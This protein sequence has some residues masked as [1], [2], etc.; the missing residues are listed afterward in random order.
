[1]KTDKFEKTIRQKLEGI[2]PDFQEDNWVQMQN[3]MQAHTP[4]TIWQQYSSWVGYAAAA[5]VT[6]VIAF[7]Y[8]N[9][10]TQ[11][12]DLVADVAKLK[13]QIEHINNTSKAL[14]RADSM[15][16]VQNEIDNA[17]SLRVGTPKTWA[18][19][20]DGE[21]NISNPGEPA[22]LG[23]YVVAKRPEISRKQQRN[24]IEEDINYTNLKPVAST[25]VF[26][27]TLG[28]NFA[29]I[30]EIAPSSIQ[31]GNNRGMNYAL[32]SRL[33][34][35]ETKKLWLA[36]TVP[37]NKIASVESKNIEKETKTEN[38]IPQ[39]NIRSP[40]R[41]GAGYQFEGNNQ[42]KTIV[43]EVLVSKKIS[44]SAGVSWLKIKPIEFLSERV[45]KERNKKDFRKMHPG[46]VPTTYEVTNI[47]VE[48]TLVQI[49]LTVAFRNDIAN[50]FSYFIGAGTHVA[51]NG[52]EKISFD[53]RFPKYGN[54][55]QK[56]SFEK[57]MDTP[58]INSLNI[59]AGIEKTWHPIVVQVEGYLYTYFT[60]LTVES[61][62]TGPGVK[63]KILYQIGK[64]M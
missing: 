61:Q 15:N 63:M 16:V 38:I 44:I 51:I 49:P 13:S 20:V 56:Q 26:Q 39:L 50:D 33:S 19:K 45:F 47:N 34:P 12:N 35:R 40:Y 28:D 60:P 32:A 37:S 1:M 3:Y 54:E 57:K 4:P 46:Q 43:G 14:L 21:Q 31:T 36:S 11:N 27:K 5:C 48:P 58:M 6:A 42:V 30:N 10:L 7:L 9:Q 41:F 64:K 62:R 23:Q 52:K 59:N 18:D 17:P 53:S 25:T 22:K 55:F 2:S 29:A 24:S 8:V